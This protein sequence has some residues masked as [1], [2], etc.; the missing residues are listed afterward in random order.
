MR[1][2]KVSPQHLLECDAIIIKIHNSIL[3]YDSINLPA[4]NWRPRNE[5]GGG[6]ACAVLLR[7]RLDAEHGQYDAVRRVRRPDAST[8]TSSSASKQGTCTATLLASLVR[9]SMA[10]H[11][12]MVREP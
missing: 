6:N 2:I 7:V 10:L 8:R 5:G 3:F 4:K 1:W 11:V 12:M 9:D